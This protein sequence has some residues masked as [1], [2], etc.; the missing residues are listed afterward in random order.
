M[1]TRLV[2]PVVL[3]TLFTLAACENTADGVKKDAAIAS[4]KVAEAGS[5]AGE[6][7]G[8]GVK[9]ADVKTALMADSLVTG[10]EIDVDTNNDTKTVALTGTVATEAIRARAEQVAKDNA[11]GFTVV[12]KLV[13]K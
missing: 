1:R 13:V 11:T 7:I 12:N 6:A 5:E 10:S 8:G 3:C 2:A 4:E 9:T